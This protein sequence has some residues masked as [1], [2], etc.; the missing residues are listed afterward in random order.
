VPKAKA[1]KGRANQTVVD[2]IHGYVARAIL[3]TFKHHR[4]TKELPP[5][6]FLAQA[7]KFLE[8]TGSTD[9]AR[10]TKGPD[11]LAGLL[12]EYRDDQPGEGRPATGRA[13]RGP[14][15]VDFSLP[16]DKP[17]TPFPDDQ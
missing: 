5:A 6:N 16:E 4:K 13:S 7:I 14:R 3:D 10:N 8:K 12:E 2:D 1:P 17:T 11:R 15:E 9:A